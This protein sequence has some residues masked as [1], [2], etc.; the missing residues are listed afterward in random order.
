MTIENLNLLPSQKAPVVGVIDPDAYVASTVVSGWISMGDFDQIQAIVLAGTLGTA[1]TLD[2]KLEQALDAAGTGVKDIVGKAITQLTQAGAD[3][4]KQAV[5]NLQS[6][7]LDVN[8]AFDF[9][10]LSMTIGVATSDAGAVITGH[11]A[12]Y[13]PGVD[14]LSVDEVIT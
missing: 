3:S 12:R 10:R 14:L 4:D 1:A 8:G 5:I 7:E 2:A 6:Q 11:N 9:A 13:A